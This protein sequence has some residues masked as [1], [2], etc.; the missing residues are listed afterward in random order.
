MTAS[1]SPEVPT[2]ANLMGDPKMVRAFRRA[3]TR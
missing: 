3:S 2:T 1:Q